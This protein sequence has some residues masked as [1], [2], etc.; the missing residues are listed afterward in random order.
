VI[1][2]SIP[3]RP[4]AVALRKVTELLAREL[5]SPSGEAPAWSEFEWLIAEAACAM[6]GISPALEGRLRW[7]GPP[8]FEAFLEAQHQHCLARHR[9]IEQLLR[10]MDAIARSAGVPFVALKGAALHGLG[11][12]RPGERPM[13]DV[14]LLVRAEDR[15]RMAQVLERCGYTHTF[16]SRRHQVFKPL[17]TPVPPNVRP[18]EHLDNPIKVEIHT[19][20]AEPLPLTEIDITPLLRHEPHPGLNAYPSRARLMMHLLL[21]ASGNIRARALRCIQLHDIVLLAQ[22][23]ERADFAEFADL[24]RACEGSWWAAAPLA[25]AAHYYP[26]GLPKELGQPLGERC[27]ALLRK[28]LRRNRLTDVS[29]S[30]IY[31][32]AFPGLEWSRSLGEAVG[33]A[34]TRLW[35]D[36]IALAELKEGSAQIIG[37]E[38]VPWYGLPH[39]QR[40]LRWVFSRPPRVQ[41]LLCVRA[42]LAN[43]GEPL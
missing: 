21:H 37:G 38:S 25:L 36:S 9:L 18:G 28:A 5:A 33:F 8:S 3:L 26:Q 11:I 29:W 41:T 30:N 43:A 14:D 10:D 1:A 17:R 39:A 13:G 31:V 19:R 15:E 6:Q 20:I 24:Q 16:T 42:A 4:I 35:P 2:L 27:P 22:N 12:Y 34:R 40:I 32:Q 7:H 23:F